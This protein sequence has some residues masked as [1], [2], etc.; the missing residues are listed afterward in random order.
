[1]YLNINE[2]L[3]TVLDDLPSLEEEEKQIE[4]T[5]ATII[6]RMNE[7][8]DKG[9]SMQEIDEIHEKIEGRKQFKDI[10]TLYREAVNIIKGKID[11][12]QKR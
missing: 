9:S 6:K 5:I 7:C 1:M 4:V 2:R 10:D 3:N 12:L 11:Y 8:L